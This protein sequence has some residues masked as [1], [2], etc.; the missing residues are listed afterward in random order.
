[1]EMDPTVKIKASQCHTEK[2]DAGFTLIEVMISMVVLTIGLLALLAS[3]GVAL[4][5][6]QNT[7][8]DAIAREKA[9]EALESIYSA[10]QTGQITFDEIANVSMG[11]QGIF[12]SGWGPLKDAGPDG[13]DGT[14]DDTTSIPIIVPGP[15]GVLAGSTPPDVQVN[16]GAFQRQIAIT[17][18]NSNLTQITVSI[19]YPVP[20]G[21][22]KTYSV[23]TLMSSYY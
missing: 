7:Q 12:V 17:S 5:S 3:L 10:R 4:A 18:V 11:G 8:L 9:S 2:R 15:S 19:R 1:M 16:L 6:T 21:W 14:A 22:S 13:I 20:Q 23:Q